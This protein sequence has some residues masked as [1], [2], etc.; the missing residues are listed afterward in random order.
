[1]NKKDKK[2]KNKKEGGEMKEKIK[3]L[4]KT[5]NEW[6]EKNILVKEEGFLKSKYK[7][8]KMKYDINYEILTIIGKEERYIKINLNQIYKIE[9]KGNQ[10]KIYLDNDMTISLEVET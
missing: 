8:E 2:R 10:I 6:N 4:Q 5:L 3:K 9:Q 1:L 7:I